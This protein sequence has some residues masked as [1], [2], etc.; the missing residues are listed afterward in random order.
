M[1]KRRIVIIGSGNVGAA[2]S[3][4]LMYQSDI[5]EIVLLDVNRERALGVAMDINHGIHQISTCFIRVGTYADCVDSDAVIICAGKN[6]TKNQTREELLEENQ[7]IMDQILTEMMPYYTDSFV[8]VVSNPVDAL[9]EY[10]IKRNIFSEKKVIGTGCLLDTSR[11]IS[12][13]SDY[14][15]VPSSKIEA[16]AVGKH[17]DKHILLWEFV[18]VENV[19]I[20]KYC[21]KNNIV[22]NEKIKQDLH[23]CV[24]NMGTE[25]IAKKGISQ[26]GIAT[27]V[28]YLISIIFGDKKVLSVVG[29]ICNDENKCVKSRLCYIGNGG[30]ENA[31]P[32]T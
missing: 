15:K 7:K 17:G 28:A 4:A 11:W 29:T 26:Y 20:K 8:I 19:S 5:Q 18:K 13:L 30:I 1:K 3:Y 14:L 27:V 31:F 16:Y 25:I 9:T 32:N 2:I 12:V 6:R 21:E 10:I 23:F 22:W 24:A